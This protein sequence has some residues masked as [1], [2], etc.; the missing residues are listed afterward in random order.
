MG[1]VRG[2]VKVIVRMKGKKG[3]KRRGKRHY[4]RNRRRG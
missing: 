3:V 1:G 4:D 2:K